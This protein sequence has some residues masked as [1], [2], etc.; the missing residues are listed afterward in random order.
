MFLFHLRFFILYIGWLL[1]LRFFLAFDNSFRTEIENGHLKFLQLTFSNE[2]IVVS[3]AIVNIVTAFI[4]NVFLFVL[5][6]I[7]FFHSADNLLSF[8]AYTSLGTISI[9]CSTLFNSM[10]SAKSSNRFLLTIISMPVLLPLLYTFSL[11]DFTQ[12]VFYFNKKFLFILVYAIFYFIL[13][14]LFSD[15]LLKED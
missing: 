10:I 9:V 15:I 13:S 6:N 4:I 1:F 8:F 2:L 5:F 3:K 11:P 14:V 12:N 7:F